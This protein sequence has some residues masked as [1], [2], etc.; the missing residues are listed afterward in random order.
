[1]VQWA[2]PDHF[3]GYGEPPSAAAM[4]SYGH[5]HWSVVLSGACKTQSKWQSSTLGKSVDNIWT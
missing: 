3:G 1:M 5:G 2:E 4:V